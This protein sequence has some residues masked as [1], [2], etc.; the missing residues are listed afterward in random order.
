[1]RFDFFAARSAHKE[2]TETSALMTNETDMSCF[3]ESGYAA[4]SSCS[5]AKHVVR[6][7]DLAGM[8][9]SGMALGVQANTQHSHART[10]S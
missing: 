6:E 9:L 1:M 10:L 7:V 5:S 4:V 8:C 3:N 2:F